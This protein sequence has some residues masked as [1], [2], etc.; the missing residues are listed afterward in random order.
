MEK[1]KQQNYRCSRW[2]QVWRKWTRIR[3]YKKQEFL[4]SANAYE[5]YYQGNGT[6]NANQVIYLSLNEENESSWSPVYENDGT[7]VD[8]D[9]KTAYIPQ[10]FKVSKLPTMNKISKGLVIK[11]SSGN[12]K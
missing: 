11:D 12:E 7:Y 4:E 3:W 8:E 9:G 5:G 1:I 10:G 2:L 6:N